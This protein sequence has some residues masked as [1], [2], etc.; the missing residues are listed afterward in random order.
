MPACAAA[1]KSA[2]N[3]TT[4]YVTL[5]ATHFFVPVAI[6]TI[7]A[8]CPQSAEFIEDLGTRIAAITNELLEK[9]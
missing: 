8:W 9:T 6:E 1:E 2:V 3:K 5:A 4:K 7:G